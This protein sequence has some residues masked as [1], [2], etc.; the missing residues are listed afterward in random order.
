MAKTKARTGILTY[1]RCGYTFSLVCKE[2]GYV[3]YNANGLGIHLRNT[4]NLNY[5]QYLKK[6]NHH[7]IKPRICEYCG[8]IFQISDKLLRIDLKQNKVR[9]GCSKKCNA[10]LTCKKKYGDEKYRN[11]EK[12]KQTNLKNYGV[13]NCFQ[14]LA[15]NQK[16][17]IEKAT[18]I[19]KNRYDYSKV[20]YKG[21]NFPT[22]IICKH[23]NNSFQQTPAIHLAGC[24]CP[25]CC[26]SKGELAIRDW[27]DAN[28]IQYISQHSFRECKDK[29]VLPFDFYLPEYNLCIE[30]QGKQHYKEGFIFFEHLCKNKLK[31][32]EKFEI[33][34][35]HDQI[36]ENFCKNNK[37]VLL[38]IK[39][40][41]NINKKLEEYLL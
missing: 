20:I 3:A 19:H 15:S 24:G 26:R 30:F 34:Q 5:L 31:A 28:D 40:D 37:I 38:K 17:F 6:Y 16:Q 18:V 36:K 35:K 23:C 29:R 9:R 10:R 33:L 2:C 13:E 32:K 4:H 11:K 7:Y 22:E 39:Y 27:L 41:D 12:R 8:N 14:L 21:C 25:K 1:N